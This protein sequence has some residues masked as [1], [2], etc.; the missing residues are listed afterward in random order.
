[1]SR[2]L[3]LRVDADLAD[4]IERVA[5]QVDTSRSDLLRTLIRDGLAD[6][7]GDHLDGEAA[8]SQLDAIKR[9]EYRNKRAA[10]FRSNAGGRLLTLF[11]SG[12]SPD[13]AET[14]MRSYR[15]E[16]TELLDDPD[17]AAWVR[18][19]LDIYR[20]A[21]P[22]APG[23]LASWI[24]DEGPAH[25]VRE[26]D[27]EPALD[28][29]AAEPDALGAGTE[30]AALPEPPEPRDPD[31]TPRDAVA[32]TAE[33]CEERGLDPAD[34]TASMILEEPG[35]RDLDAIREAVTA[36]IEEGDADE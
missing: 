23:L 29:G 14:A 9:S 6:L 27:V 28:D 36:R 20:A 24:K 18:E 12:L 25:N 4:R 5:E 1:M 7:D 34:L 35:D 10:W 31:G 17:K 11:N 30:P 19:G 13:E 21:Y 32:A 2:H 33:M 16:A 22:D 8:R 26:V 15:R 3:S